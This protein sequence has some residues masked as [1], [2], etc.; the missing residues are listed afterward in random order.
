V[1]ARGRLSLAHSYL[2]ALADFADLFVVNYRPIAVSPHF[3]HVSHFQGRRIDETAHA[4]ETHQDRNY[5]NTY[6]CEAPCPAEIPASFI[7]KMNREY[8]LASL[9]ERIGE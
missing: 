2:R 8:A 3:G 6:E 5:T 7:G 9:R 4:K 1:L